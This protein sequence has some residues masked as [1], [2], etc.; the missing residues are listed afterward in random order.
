MSWL[1][2]T[3]QNYKKLDSITSPNTLIIDLT[4]TKPQ[5]DLTFREFL[6]KDENKGKTLTFRLGSSTWKISENSG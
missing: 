6:N 1:F 2:E 5:K 3:Q 4:G